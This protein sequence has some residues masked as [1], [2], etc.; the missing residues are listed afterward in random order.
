M[1]IAQDQAHEY[2]T[3]DLIPCRVAFVM[4]VSGWRAPCLFGE[5][6]AVNLGLQTRDGEILNLDSKTRPCNMM[7][8]VGFRAV[9]EH[10]GS[11]G[12]QTLMRS[13]A[14][15]CGQDRRL[16]DGEKAFVG[17]VLHDGLFQRM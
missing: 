3:A 14:G 16:R 5:P 6:S 10:P 1:A 7:T 8:S 12:S 17:L 2:H 11:A 13:A 15:R 9:L 4:T